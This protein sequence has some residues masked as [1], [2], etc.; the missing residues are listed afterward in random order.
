MQQYSNG[1]TSKPYSHRGCR[2]PL[3]KVCEGPNGAQ[4]PGCSCKRGWTSEFATILYFI[5]QRQKCWPVMC[6]S[7]IHFTSEKWFPKSLMLISEPSGLRSA[8]IVPPS[9][10]KLPIRAQ[11]ILTNHIRTVT[12]KLSLLSRRKAGK[13]SLNL[14][15]DHCWAR[16]GRLAPHLPSCKCERT[17][18]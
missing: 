16:T 13:I 14:A 8:N 17:S 10:C 1:K 15:L 18:L 2:S 7:T 3:S 11:Q 6:L 4:D 12:P 5:L 9:E